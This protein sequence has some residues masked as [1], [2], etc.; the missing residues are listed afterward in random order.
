[1]MIQ[2]HLLFLKAHYEIGYIVISLILRYINFNQGYNWEKH[3]WGDINTNNLDTFLEWKNHKVNSRTADTHVSY[4]RKEFSW[5]ST[6]DSSQILLVPMARCIGLHLSI[7]ANS[8]S[9]HPCIP[10]CG[11]VLFLRTL[12]KSW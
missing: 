1:M 12:V 4:K 8:L 5:K 2:G 6:W 9:I 7:P 11:L 10:I 3:R